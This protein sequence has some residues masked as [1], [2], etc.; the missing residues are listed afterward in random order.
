MVRKRMVTI[1]ELLPVRFLLLL[2][3][4]FFEVFPD[5]PNVQQS[6]VPYDPF[7]AYNASRSP[8]LQPDRG[9][10]PGGGAYGATTMPA[11]PINDPYID[12]YYGHYQAPSNPTPPP[13]SRS[14]LAVDTQVVGVPTSASPVRGPRGPKGTIVMAPPPTSPAQYTDSPPTYDFGP[15]GAPG[16]WGN[17]G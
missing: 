15:S 6:H 10:T 14:P 7:S 9:Y 4:A 13:M 8:T 2:P 17:K 12:P 1:L 3:R 11:A 16:R 5:N